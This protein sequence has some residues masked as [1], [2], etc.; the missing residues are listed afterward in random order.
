[1]DEKEDFKLIKTEKIGI[2]TPDYEI[3][4]MC[5]LINHDLKEILKITPDYEIYYKGKFYKKDKELA[6]MLTD[7]C[8]TVCNLHKYKYKE[9]IMDGNA[10]Y[11]IKKYDEKDFKG[12]I[13][14]PDKSKTYYLNGEEYNE[15]EY[16]D[17]NKNSL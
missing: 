6:L 9:R 1:M 2:G 5:E 8:A 11:V 13:E 7:I 10:W 3:Y 14:W 16:R 17:L 12:S 4:Y 15:D